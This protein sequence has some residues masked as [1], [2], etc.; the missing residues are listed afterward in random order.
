MKVFDLNQFSAAIIYV[1]GNDAANGSDPELFEEKYDQLIRYIKGVNNQC[2]IFLCNMCPRG[3]TSTSEVN[4]LIKSLS[5]DHQ[6]VMIDVHKT[7]YDSR[8][9]V[10]R[11]YYDSDNIHL[12]SSGIKRLLNAINNNISI[13]QDYDRCTFNRRQQRNT[14]FSHNYN[15]AQRQ[16]PRSG[17]RNFQARR[18]EVNTDREETTNFCYKCGESNH[19]T[20]S[21]KHKQ[22]LKCFQC[23]FF[24]HKSGRCLQI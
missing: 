17:R 13:V 16:Q 19:D 11:R 18:R 4:D 22:Q 3:D 6:V 14:K 15:R 10:I 21:C 12:S 23:G 7:F 2:Q 5:E 20:I 1:G 24:G 9:N 8:N